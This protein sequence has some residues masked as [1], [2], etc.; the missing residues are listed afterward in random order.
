MPK[1]LCFLGGD[2]RVVVKQRGAVV[3]EVERLRVGPQGASV[4]LDLSALSEGSAA[5]LVLPYRH[6]AAANGAEGSAAT[7]EEAASDGPGAAAAAPLF[8][9]PILVAP[10]DVAAEL[11][12]LMRR[13]EEAC[14]EAVAAAPTAM[15]ADP[16]VTRARAYTRHFS[17]L[18]SDMAALVLGC[19]RL[20][21]ASVPYTLGGGG[22]G[23]WDAPLGVEQRAGAGAALHVARLARL[24][25]LGDDLAAFM[26]R[27]RLYRTLPYIARQTEAAGFQ[28]Y[29]PPAAGWEAAEAAEAG[30]LGVLGGGPPPQLTAG[31]GGAEADQADVGGNDDSGS[32]DGDDDT[33]HSTV[34][35]DQTVTEEGRLSEPPVAIAAFG[36]GSEGVL[37]A[38]VRRRR[39]RP[40]SPAEGHRTGRTARDGQGAGA[41]A[42]A[43]AEAVAA[44]AP[45]PPP[46]Q[47]LLLQRALGA[48][49]SGF[50]EVDAEKRFHAFRCRHANPYN[51][52]AAAANAALALPV[53]AAA[54]FGG[55][56]GVLGAGAGGS[57]GHD[58]A[59]DSTFASKAF[60]PAGL[61]S[62]ADGESPALGA[63]LGLAVVLCFATL[64]A[65][66]L[67]ARTRVATNPKRRD[68][69]VR[70]CM[71]SCLASLWLYDTWTRAYGGQ[72]VAVRELAALVVVVQP[73]TYNAAF[74][75]LPLSSS[76]P[77]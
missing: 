11:T 56:G 46:R 51:A 31:G 39:P 55:G 57:G 9:A 62:S 60:I 54:A 23:V 58:G 12:D 52:H 17:D 25:R 76:A 69:C 29:D 42:G 4:S 1:A 34:E 40:D 2:V 3:A 71:L 20:A 27:S 44:A 45:P 8:Y 32:S 64:P 24:R 15:E 59:A 50:R 6:P 14:A 61:H 72:L 37:G 53:A 21:S 30:N 41:E 38:A 63:L 65:V 26:R 49:W 13:M 77:G 36:A 16:R 75:V 73:A 67:W 5:L 22:D 35:L 68:D 10:P 7:D 48:V 19:Q 47:L 43:A 33:S 66:V 28:L 74:R 70:L 18:T